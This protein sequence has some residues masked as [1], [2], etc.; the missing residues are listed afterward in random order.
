M[1]SDITGNILLDAVEYWH[2]RAF[3]VLERAKEK[4]AI[5]V[6]HHL[7]K[8]VAKWAFI[9]VAAYASTT[10]FA[11]CEVPGITIIQTLRAWEKMPKG[12]FEKMTQAF[13]YEDVIRGFLNRGEYPEWIDIGDKG[14]LH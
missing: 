4:V 1:A 5:E 2:M 6:A 14:G 10:E 12:L 13:S 9:R 3:Y 11:D 8:S 7:P